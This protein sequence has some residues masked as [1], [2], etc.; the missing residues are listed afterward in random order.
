MATTPAA[1]PLST[2]CSKI[3]SASVL[4]SIGTSPPE[5]HTRPAMRANLQAILVRRHRLG[6]ALL[7]GAHDRLGVTRPRAAHAHA[8]NVQT[9][10]RDALEVR[11]DLARRSRRARGGQEGGRWLST[12]F[13]QRPQLFGEAHP[14]VV[15]A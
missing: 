13:L 8:G 2:A 10:G 11:P 15:P 3:R 4:T 14:L 12:A 5:R 9:P 1:A 7:E 6:R